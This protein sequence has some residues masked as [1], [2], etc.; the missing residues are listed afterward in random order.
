MTTLDS[1]VVGLDGSKVE[2]VTI[3]NL[4]G[5]LIEQDVT[6]T[7]A[8]GLSVS[9]QSARNGSSTFNHFETVATNADGSL[10]DTIWDTNSSGATSDE[11]IATT[12]ANGLDKVVQVEADGGGG[13]TETSID[14]KTL[15]ADGSSTLVQSE[16]GANGALIDQ[17][18]QTT[19]AN[20]LTIT[21]TY[22]VNGDGVAVDETKSDV[23]A[24]NAD[25]STTERRRRAMRAEARNPAASR[26]PA[27]T[28]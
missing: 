15:N 27:R 28:G 2:T 18:V 4:N 6:T 17:E 16:R 22:D 23:T 3:L 13:V 8:N 1:V 5:G 24:L 14:A 7:S 19:S 9:L 21:T 10:T 26:I 25:G 12:T 11:I 20:G